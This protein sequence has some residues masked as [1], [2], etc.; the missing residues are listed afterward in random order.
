MGM[1]FSGKHIFIILCQ[2]IYYKYVMNFSG[3][4]NKM[5]LLETESK[6]VTEA[7]RQGSG[8]KAVTKR[9]LRR[10]LNRRKTNRQRGRACATSVRANAKSGI[11]QDTSGRADR[12]GLEVVVLAWRYPRLEREAE[13][14]PYGALRK[15][16]HDPDV[17]GA[18]CR[19][20]KTKRTR[21]ASA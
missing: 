16:R 2:H 4:P 10:S 3:S 20:H 18:E 1:H 8:R 6:E 19:E 12:H 9:S 17:N 7:K 14:K 5:K 15:G 13:V 21:R 11:L